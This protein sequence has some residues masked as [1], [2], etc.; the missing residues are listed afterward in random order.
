MTSRDALAATYA[1][2]SGS[3]C[4]R[5]RWQPRIF[6]TGAGALPSG[7]GGEPAVLAGQPVPHLEHVTRAAQ[8]LGQL[9]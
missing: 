2:T 4:S 6:S 1:E 9:G 7:P 5:T 3:I 8:V